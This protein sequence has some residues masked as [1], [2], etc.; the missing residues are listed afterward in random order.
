MI[1][2]I[3]E[4]RIEEADKRAR[5]L[6]NTKREKEARIKRTDFMSRYGISICT[7]IMEFNC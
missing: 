6:D 3:A 5:E 1:F 7:S 4:A 2:V